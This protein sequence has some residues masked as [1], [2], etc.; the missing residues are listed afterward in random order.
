MLVASARTTLSAPL[1][2]AQ[3][4]DALTTLTALSSIL[5]ESTPTQLDAHARLTQTA[6]ATSAALQSAL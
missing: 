4:T 5:V 6:R 2:S 3:P 1:G